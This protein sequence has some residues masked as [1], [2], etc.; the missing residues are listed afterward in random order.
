MGND[1][2]L[3]MADVY[4]AKVV[5]ILKLP[6]SFKYTKETMHTNVG[7]LTKKQKEHLVM[8][9]RESSH[10]MPNPKWLEGVLLTYFDLKIETR[11]R[12]TDRL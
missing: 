4:L 5:D 11:V 2:I 9:V 3:K 12:I 10:V 1:T 6:R 8:L 7:K